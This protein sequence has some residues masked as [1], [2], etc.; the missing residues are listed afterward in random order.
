MDERIAFMATSLTDLATQLQNYQAGQTVGVFEGNTKKDKIDFLLGNGA[1][2]AYINYA[3]AHNESKSLAQIWVKGIK[4]DWRLLYRTDNRPNR[5][6]LPTYPFARKR[7]WVT[8]EK[9]ATN[10]LNGVSTKLHP[11]IHINESDVFAI[12]YDSLFTGKEFFFDEHVIKGRKILPG[13]AYMEMVLE[14]GKRALG[15]QITNISDVIWLAPIEI[16][17]IEGKISTRLYPENDYFK[18]DIFSG[19]NTYCTGRLN[20]TEVQQPEKRNI[21]QLLSACTNTI[22]GKDFEQL[23]IETGFGYGATFLNSE[24]L[25]YNATSVSYTHLTLPTKRI[26]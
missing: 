15:Q 3:L 23:M 8:P 6:S 21:Q 22:A 13:V 5:V 17:Q 9:S 19:K 14:V 1:G 18:F 16:D 25:S 20:T 11:L 4:I 12:R 7:Y 2:Q 10:Q 24:K 26:V